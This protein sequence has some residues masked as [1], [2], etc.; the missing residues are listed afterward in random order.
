MGAGSTKDQEDLFDDGESD[1][2][3]FVPD[4]YDQLLG[5]N[6]LSPRNDDQSP[7]NNWNLED[8]FGDGGNE[9]AFKEIVSDLEKPSKTRSADEDRNEA[10]LRDGSNILELLGMVE[11]RD[12]ASSAE[13]DAEDLSNSSSDGEDSDA[14][15]VFKLNAMKPQ[16]LEKPYTSFFLYQLQEATVKVMHM[17]R[18][19]VLLPLHPELGHFGVVWKQVDKAILP[20]LH[21]IVPLPT[22]QSPVLPGIPT[23][24]M[25]VAYGNTFG[26]SISQS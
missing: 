22:V 15:D 1:T 11:P 3:A 2:E 7:S 21:G 18:S 16:E 10:F 13:N 17:L 14:E 25:K 8:L 6:A 12:D 9:T 24:V 19:D 5:E 20:F 23:R 26:T 4:V